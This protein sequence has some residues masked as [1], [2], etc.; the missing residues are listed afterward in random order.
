MI[1]RPQ[2]FD[3][4]LPLGGRPIELIFHKNNVKPKVLIKPSRST[5]MHLERIDNKMVH[6][7]EYIAI[8]VK[9]KVILRT[10]Q[11]SKLTN[12]RKQISSLFTD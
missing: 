11:T 4:G 2:I 8:R 1:K 12:A 3:D 9:P 5:P 10:V 6:L 7:I